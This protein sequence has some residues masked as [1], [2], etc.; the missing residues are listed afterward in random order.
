MTELQDTDRSQW[1]AHTEGLR[2]LARHLAGPID[3]DDH[4]QDTWV[5][6]LDH[7]PPSRSPRAWFRQVLRNSVRARARRA[8]RWDEL[9]TLVVQDRDVPRP[10]EHA[11]AEEVSRV[12]AAVLEDLDEPYRIVL[13]ERF[14]DERSLTE[15][16]DRLGCPDGTVRWRVHEGLRRMRQELDRRFGERS[17]W[18]G[19]VVVLGGLPTGAEAPASMGA[20]MSTSTKI[21]AVSSAL[22]LSGLVVVGYV[23]C[24]AHDEEPTVEPRGESVEPAS[25]PEASVAADVEGPKASSDA[26]GD[27]SGRVAPRPR[28]PAAAG[29]AAPNDTPASTEPLLR[30]SKEC[31]HVFIAAFNDDPDSADAVE[32]LVDAAECFEEAGVIGK[33]IKVRTVLAKRY[34]ESPYVE[35]NREASGRLFWAIVDPEAGLETKVARDCIAEMGDDSAQAHVDAADCMFDGA[36]LAGAALEYRKL[37]KTRSGPLDTDDND[38]AIADLERRIAKLADRLEDDPPEDP[39]E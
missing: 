21:K 33:A 35:E 11:E 17:R 9:Q 25:E 30:G 16:A 15:I 38:A 14:Y 12:L 20:S 8:R 24:V 32:H 22:A 18:Y 13:R 23:A 34:P 19:A 39:A 36:A 6:A 29:S 7:P 3:A 1:V 4:V 27:P 28:R 26:S 31:E 5:A 10:D 2:G 37:A